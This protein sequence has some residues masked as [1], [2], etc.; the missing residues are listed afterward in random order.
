MFSRPPVLRR[1]RALLAA[2]TAALALALSACGG[3]TA[4]TAADAGPPQ[5]G[6][7]L[8]VA[9]FP[10]NAAFAC[11]DPFQTYWIEH[12]T[13]IR[14]VADSLTDQDATNGEIK[15]WIAQSWQVTPDGKQYTFHLRDGVTFSDGTALDAAAVKAN[16]DGWLATVSQTH[17]AAY[18]SSYILGLSGAEVV[19]PK[20][21]RFDFATPNSSFL[22]ATSTTNLA[23][24]S[25]SSFANSPKDRCLG[26]YTAS[27]QFTLDN[28][29]PG[30][31]ITL[32]K[33]PGYAWGSPLSANTGAAH[34]DKVEFSYV[35]EDSVRTGDLV[36][37]AVDIAWPRNPFTV[38]DRELI[39]R[40][41]ATVQSRSLPGVSY[42]F[43]ANTTAGKPL[44][45][46]Q[47]RAA[48][49]KALDLPTYAKTV[50]GQD[51][52][53]VGGGYDATTPYYLSVADKL[54]HD[55]AGAAALLDSAGWTLGP[56]GYRYKN[57]AKLTLTFPLTQFS[58][59]SELVQDQLKHVG[60]DLKLNTV[61]TA[62]LPTTLANGDYD[63]T[64][65]YFTRADPGALQF[66]L[67]PDLANSKALATNAMTPEVRGQVKALFSHAIQTTDQA[68]SK[69]AYAD[70]QALLIDKGV[71]FPLF[72]RVQ[73]AGVRNDVHGFAFTSESFLKLADVWKTPESS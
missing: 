8:K 38:E 47:V 7:T 58:A 65:T 12:R 56:D 5:N 41:D 66:I 52:P 72:E 68:T 11:V 36:S 17:G 18:G 9:F 19:D 1:R 3:G 39:A 21:V 63:L 22:Q 40:S 16:A 70:L 64:Q 49:P 2:S 32:S 45:D 30:E 4:S 69:K 44:A 53:V 37:G 42:T 73:Y 6:G 26:R 55:P 67:D 34:L 14:N 25:P 60:I 20:T 50:F 10:D 13:V 35:A 31:G 51:Y 71:T 54:K 46:P 29:T 59:G 62:E 27:G 43:F 28:Y 48:L 33:R 57:G 24:I 23:L 15:P 61:T